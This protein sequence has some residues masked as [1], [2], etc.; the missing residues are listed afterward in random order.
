MKKTICALVTVLL[1]TLIACTGDDA[2]RA[3]LSTVSVDPDLLGIQFLCDSEE[4]YRIDYIASLDGE[5]LCTSGIANFEKTPL[6]DDPNVVAYFTREE[7]EGRE[8]GE[9]SLEFQLYGENEDQVMAVAGPVSM[10]L[11]FGTRYTVT[12]SGDSSGGF[13]AEL[14]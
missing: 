3:G 13:T 1:L 14:A 7:L 6:N 2:S 4:I 11:R 8:E 10:P 12:I 9:F 5:Y